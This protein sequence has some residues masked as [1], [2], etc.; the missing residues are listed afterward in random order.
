MTGEASYIELGVR[1]AD[2]AR[3]FYGRLLGWR[4][5]GDRGPGEVNSPTLSIGIHDG[6]DSSIFEVF[7]SVDDLDA[8]L[9]M[10]AQLGGRVAGDV[11]NSPGFGRWAECVD[12]QGVRFGLR[13]QASA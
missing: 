11:N 3:A 5:S 1:D 7:F 6:D 9:A 10:V 4:V 2:A 12:D 8:S 13:Q